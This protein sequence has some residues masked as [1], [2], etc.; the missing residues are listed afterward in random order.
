MC[1][2]LFGKQL[3]F[4]IHGF[5]CDNIVAER[6]IDGAPFFE[7]GSDWRRSKDRS[8]AAACG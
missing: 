6:L 4:R 3:S 8:G 2:G 5:Y 7:D 1:E